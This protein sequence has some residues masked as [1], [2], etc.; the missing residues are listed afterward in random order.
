MRRL[1]AAFGGESGKRRRREG[2]PHRRQ[3]SRVEGSPVRR[4]PWPRQRVCVLSQLGF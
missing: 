3:R 2:N 4:R 1:G